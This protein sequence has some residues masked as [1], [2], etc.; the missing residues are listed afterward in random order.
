MIKKN[1]SWWNTNIGNIERKYVNNAFNKKYFSMGKITKELEK[2]LSKIHNC[3]YCIVTNIGTSALLL[4]VLSLELKKSDEILVPA[5]TWIA[6]AQAASIT[7]CKIRLIDVKKDSPVLNEQ[8]LEKKITKK[9]KVIIPV[10]FHGHA[11]NMMIINKIAKKYRIHII[12]DAC[13]SMHVKYNNKFLGTIGDLGCFSLGMV[14]LISAGYGGFILTNNNKLHKKLLILRDHGMTRINND[15]YLFNSLNFKYSD[16]LSSIALGQIKKLKKKQQNLAKIYLLY[17]QGLKNLKKTK[18]LN[19][20]ST[21]PICI[22]VL[23]KNRNKLIDF[24]KKNNIDTSCFHPN[25]T[26]AKYLKIKGNYPNSKFFSSKCF[27]PPCGPDQ[28]IKYVKKTIK[29]IQEFDKL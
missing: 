4:S 2:K 29:K 19:N 16:I 26:E 14:S 12:E 24:L 9:T 17:K 8:I 18:L 11:C 22:D 1:L 7:G 23:T 13:K 28:S 20:E 27:M 21:F 6:T 3:K 5:H 25:L 10:H 15:K